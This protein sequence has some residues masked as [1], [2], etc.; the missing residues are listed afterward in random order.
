[1]TKFVTSLAA[2]QLV[3]QGK[4]A[5]DDPAPIEKHLPELCAQKILTGFTEDGE[6]MLV[7]RKNPITLRHLLTHT[8]GMGYAFLRPDTLERYEKKEG[9]KGFLEANIGIEGYVRP[10]L[11]E[12]GTHYAY[13][14]GVDWAGILVMRITGQTL[15]DY[16]HEHIFG[17]LGIG[18][19]ELTFLP[20]EQVK[21]RLQTMTAR[22]A[23]TQ[24]QIVPHPGWRNVAKFTP[25]MIGLQAGGAGMVGTLRAYLKFLA[26]ILKCQQPGGV[27]TPETFELV[28]SD[29]MPEG[30]QPRKDLADFLQFM[31]VTDSQQ[32]EGKV[33]H[34]LGLCYLANGS[35]DGPLPGSARWSGVAKTHYFVDPKAGIAAIC[36]TNIME[37]VPKQFLEVYSKFQRTVYDNLVQSKL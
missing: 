28:F 30:Q 29:Q 31:G 22:A 26:G 32:T 9:L 21:A 11:F 6:P 23:V 12:P 3:E 35:D 18:R 16:F 2:L 19:E 27:I 7:D 1:M 25:E 36:G 15:D 20:T 4:L 10:L 24:N 37:E 14:T 13:G 34:S 8:S 5:I 17:P 33:T